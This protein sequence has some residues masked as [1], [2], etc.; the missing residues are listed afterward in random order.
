MENQWVHLTLLGVLKLGT[1]DEFVLLGRGYERLFG[2]ICTPHGLFAHFE[3]S[4]SD[5][6]G[7]SHLF[8]DQIAATIF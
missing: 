4:A 5:Y 1:L 7:F 2:V 6:V 8:A 3:Q